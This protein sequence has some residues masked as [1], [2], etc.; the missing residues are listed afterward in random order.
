MKK[1]NQIKRI[2][3]I[4]ESV[5]PNIKEAKGNRVNVEADFSIETESGVP[6]EFTIEG[7]A[8]YGNQGIGSYEFWGARG[9]DIQMG[10]EID[11]YNLKEGSYD[12]QFEFEINKWIEHND[13]KIIERL[14]DAA[15]EQGEEEQDYYDEY[16]PE[17]YL[18]ESVEKLNRAKTIM[19]AINPTISK[20]P[21]Q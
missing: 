2:K 9:T 14:G 13:D 12:P 18:D 1:N 5:N 15:E 3:Q 8:I 4:M 16:E 7:E 11:G 19:E 10:Y 17:D 21:K 6:V 20:K